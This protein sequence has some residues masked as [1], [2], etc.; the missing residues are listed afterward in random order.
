MDD[1]FRFL[2]VG[3]ILLLSGCMVGPDFQAPPPPETSRYT[4]LPVPVHTASAASQSGQSQEL[5]FNHDIPGQWWTLFHSAVLNDMIE[6]GIAHNPSI[7]AA[8]AAV[9]MAQ[10]NWRAQVGALFPSVNLDIFAA[11]ARQNAASSSGVGASSTTIT[12]TTS[13]T[14]LTSSAPASASSDSS[15]SASSASGSADSSLGT[16]ATIF[17]VYSLALQATYTL[18]LFGGVRRQLEALGAQVDFEYFQWQATYLNLT[19]SIVT[20]AINEA[21]LRAQIEATDKLIKLQKEQLRIV[22]AQFTLG[23]ASKVDVLTQAVQVAQTEATLPPLQTAL[24]KAR[25]SMAALIG[26]LPSQV[27]LPKF[28]LSQIKLPTKIPVTLP[29]DIVRQRPDIQAAEAILHEASA[30]IGVATAN[31]FPQVTLAANFGWTATQLSHLFSSA[32][33]VWSIAGELLQP[34]FE[35]GTLLA[36]RRA[37]IAS[38]NQA[39][40]QYRQTVLQAFQTVSD[41]LQALEWDAQALKDQAQAEIYAKQSLDLAAKQYKLGAINY[42][43]LLDAQRQFHQAEIQRIQAEALRYTDTATL[44]QALGGGWWNRTINKE[45]GITALTK[46]K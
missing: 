7:V 35:G 29:S 30:K 40:A 11:R 1:I 4:P 42:I 19:T 28:Y 8:E 6:E 36:Q 5:L 16:G 14:G 41:V 18:D 37:A 2:L 25:D 21:S 13:S 45:N 44:F 46:D 9:R 43:L 12:P 31:F 26:Q 24:A 15:S 17:N 10:E 33:N 23:G 38:Y 20:A 3:L 27:H 32:N 39:A 34:V 22:N